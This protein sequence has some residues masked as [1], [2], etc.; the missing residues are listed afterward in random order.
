[1]MV[2]FKKH[3]IWLPC[4]LGVMAAVGCSSQ[5]PSFEASY[6]YPSEQTKNVNYICAVVYEPQY[7]LYLASSRQ[8]VISKIVSVEE[9]I[10][11]YFQ[12]GNRVVLP[13]ESN[14]PLGGEFYCGKKQHYPCL[15]GNNQDTN[16][17]RKRPL[18]LKR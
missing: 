13:I 11:A 10:L 18:Q 4:F 8:S 14:L 7:A 3:R 17:A 2:D 12:D 5:T 9:G 16:C 6:R 1:M 15:L